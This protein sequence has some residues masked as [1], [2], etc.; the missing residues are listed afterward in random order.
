LTTSGEVAASAAHVDDP[1]PAA[2]TKVNPEA[3]RPRRER[4]RQ[5]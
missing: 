4:G 2:R 3:A 1:S 5:C